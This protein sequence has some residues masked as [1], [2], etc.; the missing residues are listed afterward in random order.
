M[1]QKLFGILP[2]SPTQPKWCN[3]NKK[4]QVKKTKFQCRTDKNPCCIRCPKCELTQKSHSKLFKTPESLWRHLWQ[5]HSLDQNLYPSIDETIKILEK[6]SIS[7]TYRYSDHIWRLKNNIFPPNRATIYLR[8][9]GTRFNS[10]KKI[11]I[12]EGFDMWKCEWRYRR[13][14]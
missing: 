13:V 7:I 6:I 10:L 11:Q 1:H 9:S 14:V 8:N 12:F 3:M 2:S 5:S 4:L